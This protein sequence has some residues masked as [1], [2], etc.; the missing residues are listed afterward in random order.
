MRTD[1]APSQLNRYR[2]PFD[3]DRPADASTFALLALRNW[4]AAIAV[5][6]SIRIAMKLISF[7]VRFLAGLCL[8]GYPI[9]LALLGLANECASGLDENDPR[10]PSVSV[11]IAA[12]NEEQ[13]IG[14]KIAETLAWDY[15]PEKLHIL[16]ASD[17][18]EDS[19]DEIVR[20]FSGTR[21][22]AGPDG[23]AGR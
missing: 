7:M 15:P 17:A 21:S 12:R 20:E 10:S 8:C 5:R 13:D 22:H 9:L 3:D 23:S 6:W 16:V 18:S 1:P 2:D 14:W 11:L 19:T 4:A